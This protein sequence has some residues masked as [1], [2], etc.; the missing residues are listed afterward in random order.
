MIDFLDKEVEL[1]KGGTVQPFQYS[2]L[3]HT[4]DYASMSLRHFE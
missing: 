1:L 2:T 3:T 4:K